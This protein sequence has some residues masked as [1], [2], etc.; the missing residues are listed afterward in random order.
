MLVALPLLALL[1][2]TQLPSRSPERDVEIGWARRAVT[3]LLICGVAGVVIVEGLGSLGQLNT[4][5]LAFAWAAVVIA[6]LGYLRRTA[7][8]LALPPI[9]LRWRELLRAERA[10]LAAMLGLVAA[11]GLVA[12]LS[13]PTHAAR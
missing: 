8:A 4:R 11:L 2:L 3:A 13:P 12:L 7:R 6:A 9:A 1:L 5:G 10:L